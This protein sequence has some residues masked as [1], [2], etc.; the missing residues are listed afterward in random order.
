MV[1]KLTKNFWIIGMSTG[2]RRVLSKCDFCFH[3]NALPVCQV[4]ADL[5]HEIIVLDEPTFTQVGVDCYEVKS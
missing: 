4:M 2:I 3:L 1:S 5:L